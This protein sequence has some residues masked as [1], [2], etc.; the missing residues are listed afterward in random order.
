MQ[1]VNIML[2]EE[3][4]KNNNYTWHCNYIALVY[5]PKRTQRPFAKG[6]L[7]VNMK[8]NVCL[9]LITYVPAENIW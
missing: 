9:F 7:S 3:P 5:N 6:D 4:F 1:R 8:P 2:N